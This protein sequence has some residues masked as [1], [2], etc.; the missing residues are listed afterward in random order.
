MLSAKNLTVVGEMR[1]IFL[2]RR[3]LNSHYDRFGVVVRHSDG[4]IV[5]VMHEA[6]EHMR[7]VREWVL[8]QWGI[9]V[10]PEKPRDHLPSVPAHSHRGRRKNQSVPPP[11]T[12]RRGTK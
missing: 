11:I 3:L 10:E 12:V 1:D 8:K 5:S 4:V 9:V 2:A 6:R 7:L